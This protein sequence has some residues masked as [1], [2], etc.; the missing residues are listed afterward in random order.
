M[1]AGY[2]N[3]VHRRSRCVEDVLLP[4]VFDPVV[5]YIPD[6]FNIVYLAVPDFENVSGIVGTP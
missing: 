5:G 3:G 6:G 1:Y 4:A 2:A